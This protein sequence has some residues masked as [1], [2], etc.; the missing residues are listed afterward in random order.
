MDAAAV[1]DL[2]TKGIGVAEVLIKAEQDAGP[3]LRSIRDL[4]AGGKAGTVTQA[5]LDSC[6]AL[7]DQLIEDFNAELPPS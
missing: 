5:D 2:I 7:L 1:F 4:A 3:A 6:E